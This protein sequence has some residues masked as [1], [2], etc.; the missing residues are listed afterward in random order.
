MLKQ[1]C[2]EC[3]AFIK[4][5]DRDKHGRDYG[6]TFH[7]ATLSLKRGTGVEVSICFTAQ[8][9]TGENSVIAFELC[10]QCKLGLAK[11]FLEQ[12]LEERTKPVVCRNCGKAIF[13]S[14]GDACYMHH[15]PPSL[16]LIASP[17][18]LPGRN[19]ADHANS[20]FAEPKE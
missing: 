4:D 5:F 7:S 12:M 1:Y 14:Q 16:S 11:K 20:P 9:K 19:C 13:W 15:L 6:Q 3:G 8:K 2:D 18:I 17:R 10:D